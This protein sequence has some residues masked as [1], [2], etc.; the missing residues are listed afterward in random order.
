MELL[1]HNKASEG[2]RLKT[3]KIQKD[4]GKDLQFDQIR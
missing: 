3:R 1:R 2:N 4:K